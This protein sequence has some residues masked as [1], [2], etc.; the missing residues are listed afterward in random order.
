MAF[1]RR[2][3]TARRMI[4]MI[5]LQAVSLPNEHHL[6]PTVRSRHSLEGEDVLCMSKSYG[7]QRFLYELS[8]YRR[9]IRKSTKMGS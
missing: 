7:N 6:R 9:Q 2:W 1:I 4:L 8:S 5:C 3:I